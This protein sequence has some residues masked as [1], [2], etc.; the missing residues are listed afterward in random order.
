MV[1]LQET[2]DD[3]AEAIRER[4]TAPPEVQQLQE[5][6][7]R[8]QDELEELE[9]RVTEHSDELD[10]V[11]KKEQECT[12][13]LEHFQSQKGMV[14]NEREFTAV[15]SEIDYATKALEETTTRLDEL[16]TMI[17]EIKE[18]I[19]ARRQAR[20][21][22][23]DAQNEVT[24]TWEQRKT[25]LMQRIHNLAVHARETE[26]RLRPSHRSRFLRLLASK[27]GTAMAAVVDG[28]CSLC[29][30][31]LRPHLQQRVRRCQEII[32]CEH[33]HRILYFAELAQES[34]PEYSAG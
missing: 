32:A 4:Q 11:R 29:H 2:Y 19:D 34:A 1:R 18:D 7:Q 3:I 16:Q 33:C 10:T 30:F 9:R 21:D 28:S 24:N 15:I 25:D 31:A 13:E 12:I 5:E 27:H 6:N 20:P 26:A 14:T 8:R 23:E 22:E 17:G